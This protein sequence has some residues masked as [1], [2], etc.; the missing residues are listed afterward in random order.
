MNIVDQKNLLRDETREKRREFVKSIINKKFLDKEILKRVTAILK[1]KNEIIAGYYPLTNEPDIL[2]IA[3]STR[4]FAL[5]KIEQEHLVFY[6]WSK[7]CPL[8]QNKHKIFEPTTGEKVIP[9]VILI[10][11]VAFDMEKNRLGQG[12]GFYD[13][14]ILRYNKK[15]LFIG[16]AYDMQEVSSVPVEDHDQK[17]DIIITET[18]IIK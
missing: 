16:I 8:E 11:L 1:D 4:L 9:R 3:Y 18:R 12:A 7:G 6:S 2:D 15:A 10:P 5:P 13:K 14:T 17:L